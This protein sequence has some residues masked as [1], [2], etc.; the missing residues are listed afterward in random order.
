MPKSEV[1]TVCGEPR[2]ENSNSLARCE[3]HVREYWRE[4]SA[5]KRRSTRTTHREAAPEPVAPVPS[6]IIVQSPPPAVKRISVLV[7]GETV[8]MDIGTFRR[9]MHSSVPIAQDQT[10]S[11]QFAVVSRDL[12]Q[13]LL[14][15]AVPCELHGLDEDHY[16]RQLQALRDA[17]WNVCVEG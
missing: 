12:S 6:A 7:T 1:C 16:A 15:E 2:W 14:C 17:G 8:T 4:H 3:K 11:R 13:V 10:P 5:G 9:L